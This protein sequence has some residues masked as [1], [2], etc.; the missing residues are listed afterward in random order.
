MPEEVIEEIVSGTKPPPIVHGLQQQKKD[1]MWGIMENEIMK[2]VYNILDLSNKHKKSKLFNIFDGKPDFEN[3]KGWSTT[4]NKK[5]Y[6]VLKGSKFGVFMVNLTTVS[7][8]KTSVI[9]MIIT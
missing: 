6:G 2:D 9:M 3:C 1:T 4:V 5:K 7:F 8:L